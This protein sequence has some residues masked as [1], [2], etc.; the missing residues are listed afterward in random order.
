MYSSKQNKDSS[1]LCFCPTYEMSTGSDQN[2]AKAGRTRLAP[3]FPVGLLSYQARSILFKKSR[4]CAMKNGICIWNNL[5][6]QLLF[7]VDCLVIVTSCCS[8]IFFWSC[9]TEPTWFW[10]FFITRLSSSAVRGSQAHE[11]NHPAIWCPTCGSNA[12]DAT[13]MRSLYVIKDA[14]S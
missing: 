12:F 11:T 6:F 1:I 5:R 14:V 13:S 8:F 7:R 9:R 3:D 10:V 4:N 2:S